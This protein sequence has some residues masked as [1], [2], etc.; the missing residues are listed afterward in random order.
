MKIA[1]IGSGISGLSS[2][3]HLDSEHQVVVYEKN[4]YLGGH[5][6][7]HDIDIDGSATRIDSGFI[8]FC[9]ELYPNFSAMLD[10]LGVRS[11]PT[12]MSFGVYNQQKNLQYNATNLNSLFCQRRNLFNPQMYRMIVD[13]VRF[14][15]TAKQR[16][17]AD[18][19]TMSIDE[20]LNKHHYSDTFREDH[21]FPMIGALWSIPPRI[22]S[23]F[24]I[25][26]LVEFLDAHGLMKLWRRPQWRVLE[27][28][29][30]SYIQA[31]K[32]RLNNTEFRVNCGV[33]NVIRDVDKVLI[34]SASAAPEIFDAVIFAVHSDQA[35]MLLQ[36]PSAAENEILGNI[37]FQSNDIVVHSDESV[38]PPVKSAWSSWNV[39]F[40]A[41]QPG[42]RTIN[43]YNACYWMN[44]L[45][46]LT[47]KTNIF[48][49]LN[50]KRPIDP[51]KI[52]KKRVYH[53][54]TYS[55]SSLQAR[56]RLP[57][58]NGQNRT[59]YVGAFWAWA[60]HEDGARSAV[61]AVALLNQAFPTTTSPQQGKQQHQ[62]RQQTKN[63]SDTQS[64]H[65]HKQPA[66]V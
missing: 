16:I 45:Q 65:P 32:K 2:A 54:P 30:N 48:V 39:H 41:S 50:E 29:S 6:D 38:M 7:T 12:D 5:T 35:K 42:E 3:Y 37:P 55:K 61:E 59:F 46:G 63:L 49:S 11:K 44:S 25:R 52:L 51:N 9:P 53:H 58:I 62:H 33:T 22:V 4:N 15:I 13:I 14:Y 18:D 47:I 17:D 60:F 27:N 20:F 40:D 24:P 8:I 66:E 23:Q 36:K 34:H 21:F 56:R 10:D 31:L 28:G 64:E 57:E 1:I 26:Y 43:H 19:T